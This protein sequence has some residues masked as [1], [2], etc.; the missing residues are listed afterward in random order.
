MGA[1]R[2]F[3]YIAPKR[4]QKLPNLRFLINLP[5][6]LPFHSLL[7]VQLQSSQLQTHNANLHYLIQSAVTFCHLVRRRVTPGP[8]SS[9]T[10]FSFH[11]SQTFWLIHS[12]ISR[13]SKLIQPISNHLYPVAH[14]HYMLNFSA[15]K[16]SLWASIVCSFAKDKET[17][18][19]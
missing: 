3:S 11:Y 16:A 1:E 12:D 10:V 13:G 2:Q 17:K 9:T 7:P 18:R 4:E 5:L 8:K 14:S 19:G 15:C 6:H